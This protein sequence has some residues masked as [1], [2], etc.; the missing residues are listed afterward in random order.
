MFE[1]RTATKVKVLNVGTLVT[2][3]RKVD[4]LPGAQLSLKMLLTPEAMA[5]FDG[6]WPSILCEFGSKPK[7]D[8]PALEGMEQSTLAK[9]LKSVSLDYKQTGCALVVD[10]GLGGK[11]SNIQL[12]DVTVHSVKV[13]PMSVGVELSCKVDAPALTDPT[14]GVLSGLKATEIDMILTGPVVDDRQAGIPG[15]EGT[16]PDKAPKGGWPFPKSGKAQGVVAD[17]T[18]ATG[19]FVDAHA[20]KD[21]LPDERQVGETKVITRRSRAAAPPPGAH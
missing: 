10:R 15:T 17:E 1:L 7:E 16:D 18:D 9:H 12:D 11:S 19:A 20:P 14:R 4:E 21:A 2:K 5:M 13:K 6:R 3:D 8:Q